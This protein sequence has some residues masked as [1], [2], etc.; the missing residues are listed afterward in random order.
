MSSKPW[1]TPVL[2][3]G[4]GP[5]GLV[6]SLALTRYGVDHIV[7]ER[8]QG[9]AHTPRAHIIN[10]RTVEILRHLGVEDRFLEVS[11]QQEYMRNNLWVTSLS[12][13]EILRSEAW[14][15]SDRVVGEYSSSSPSPMANCAQTVLEPMLLDA[16]V[17]A[18][19]DIRFNHELESLEQDEDG[20]TSTIRDRISGDLI[21]VRS[22]YV[23]GADGAR[24]RVLDLAGLTVEGP[25]GL[26]HAANVWFE[27]DLTRFLEHRPGVL[28]W[29]VMPGPLPPL[30]LGTLICHKPFT[31]FVLV[32]M[33]DPNTRTSTI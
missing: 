31:E 13:Q 33:Y 8:H 7:V 5:A 19:S 25:A 14:G 26:A 28:I 21:S 23:I 6:S 24:S 9:T 10:Q 29:N 17:D 30:R 11:T 3:V 1:E 20:V 15:T 4:A 18:G 32:F 27:A 22:K 2:I 16:A 12:G